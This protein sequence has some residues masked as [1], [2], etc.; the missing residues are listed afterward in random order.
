VQDA[1]DGGTRGSGIA[2]PRDVLWTTV[3][4]PILVVKG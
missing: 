1:I 4:L 3:E 2:A